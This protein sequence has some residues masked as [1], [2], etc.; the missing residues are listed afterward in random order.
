MQD[1]IL[2]QRSDIVSGVGSNTSNLHNGTLTV[3]ESPAA[4]SPAGRAAC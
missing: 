4:L 1:L 3:A 2:Q